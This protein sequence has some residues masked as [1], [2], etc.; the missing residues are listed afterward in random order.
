MTNEDKMKIYIDEMMEIEDSRRLA[1]LLM[2][3]EPVVSN[4][5]E[6]T[7]RQLNKI[8]IKRFVMPVINY[9]FFDCPNCSKVCSDE[10]KRQSGCNGFS[11]KRL[12]AVVLSDE[13]KQRLHYILDSIAEDSVSVSK[14]YEGV[15]KPMDGDLYHLIQTMAKAIL[16]MNGKLDLFNDK[17]F[18]KKP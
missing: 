9:K 2:T 15:E 16:A 3:L 14:R 8:I 17:M 7:V 6:D 18:G 11:P 13:H 1:M 5:S 12:N 10:A 4:W